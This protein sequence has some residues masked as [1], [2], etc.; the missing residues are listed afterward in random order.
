MLCCV[1]PADRCAIM[2]GMA[3]VLS[4]FIR[5]VDGQFPGIPRDAPWLVA[6]RVSD[7][8]LGLIDFLPPEFERVSAEIAVHRSATVASSALLTGAVILSAGCQ[9]GHG[10]LLRGGVWADEDVV[11]GPHSEIKGTLLFARS[12][13]AHRNYAGDSIIGRDVN[14]EAGAVLANHF[15][16]RADKQ[17]CVR[18]DDAVIAAGVT[19]FGALIGDGCRIGANAVTSPGTLLPPGSVVPRLSLVDQSSADEGR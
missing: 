17:I 8:V 14:L 13:A 3:D 1:T 18:V 6:G 12:A 10:A 7:L 4:Q 15:N 11:I 5:D 19:K 16:E 2:N 9:I